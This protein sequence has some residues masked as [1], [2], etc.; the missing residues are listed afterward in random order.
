MIR[1]K[2]KKVFLLLKGGLGNQLFQYAAGCF[3]A[4]ILDRKLII[5]T[6]LGFSRDRYKRSY[7]LAR[8]LP[9]IKETSFYHRIAIIL[10]SKSQKLLEQKGTILRSQLKMVWQLYY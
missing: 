1:S 10:Y 4:E 5:D 7:E 9:E 3:V 8:I 2:K 6:K